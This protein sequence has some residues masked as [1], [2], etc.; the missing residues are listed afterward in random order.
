MSVHDPRDADEERPRIHGRFGTVRLRSGQGRAHDL[1]ESEDR[2]STR[3]GEAVRDLAEACDDQRV[4]RLGGE[5]GAADEDD[6]HAGGVR[7]L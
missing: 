3:L 2:R 4:R 5:F 6:A 1:A 7:A